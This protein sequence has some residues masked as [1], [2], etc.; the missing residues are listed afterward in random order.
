[1]VCRSRVCLAVV[2]QPG[3]MCFCNRLLPCFRG[4]KEI[5][6]LGYVLLQEMQ[7]RR[8]GMCQKKLLVPYLC[9]SV[10]HSLLRY[11]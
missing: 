4:D 2:A 8:P 11:L 9:C 1:M 10:T 6:V 7:R 3:W 5:P